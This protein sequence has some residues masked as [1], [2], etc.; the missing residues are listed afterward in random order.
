LVPLIAHD[1]AGFG[2]AAFTTGFTALGCVWYSRTT[3]ALWE[4]T[5][6]AGT[7]S[8]T[9]A[10]GIHFVVGYANPWHLAPAVTG[11]A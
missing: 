11:A 8:L 10:I 7:V 1:R 9:A 2:G 3:R 5:F 4:T 6:L